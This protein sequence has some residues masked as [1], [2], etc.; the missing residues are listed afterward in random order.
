MKDEAE[1]CFSA[2][3]KESGLAPSLCRAIPQTPHPSHPQNQTQLEG[4]QGSSSSRG[5]W[6]EF[7]A[8]CSTLSHLPLCL[9]LA[10]PLESRAQALVAAELNNE[11][12]MPALSICLLIGS[13]SRA[14]RGLSLLWNCWRGS[15]QAFSA[16]KWRKMGK[17]REERGS[18]QVGAWLCRNWECLVSRNVV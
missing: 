13:V 15:I 7:G 10:E 16:C 11:K 5:V 9:S 14:P 1:G 6:D 4:V 2:G 18:G 12:Y 8:V 17:G 3:N